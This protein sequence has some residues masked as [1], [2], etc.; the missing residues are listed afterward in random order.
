MEFDLV[1]GVAVLTAL[2]IYLIL[3]GGRGQRG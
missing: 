3:F 1:P 2:C